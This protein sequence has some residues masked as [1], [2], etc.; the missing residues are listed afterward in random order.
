MVNENFRWQAWFR[1]IKQILDDGQ[2]GQ[3]FFAKMHQRNRLT[4][5]HFDHG[6]GY[7]TEMEQLLL[8]EV[9]THLL[10]TSR[11]LF[12]EPESVYCRLHHISPEVV[13]EDVQVIT[14]AYT[15]M[16]E[17]I[18]DSWASVPIPGLDRPE[19]EYPWY[20]RVLEIEGT[21]GTLRLNP[22]GWIWLY[23]DNEK[24]CWPAPERAM[25][26]AHIAAQQHFIDCLESG[27]EFET[28]S[29]DTI[30]TMAL[31]YACY[32]SAEDGRVV[33]PEEMY[34]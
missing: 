23:S 12:G 5:P 30:K 32:R 9:G 20:P 18:H 7:F 24:K 29:E 31:V 22:D 19:E 3:V 33:R 25:P 21:K 11:F 2:V 10:D 15:D 27:E 14:L 34:E 28:S 8:Y 4:M 6:Q 26:K 17:V 1:S 16:T 13:G